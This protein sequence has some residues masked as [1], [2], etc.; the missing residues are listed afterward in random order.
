[1]KFLTIT[2]LVCLLS[3]VCCEEASTAAEKEQATTETSDSEEAAEQPNV[4]KDDSPK[5]KPDIDP[6]NF[7]VDVIKNGMKHASGFRDA[8]SVLP[9]SFSG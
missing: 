6:V 5:D 3:V 1:M 7:L 9:F 4:E 8:I 2:L